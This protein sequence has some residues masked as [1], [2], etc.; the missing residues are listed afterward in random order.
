MPHEENANAVSDI[1]G[2]HLSKTSTK[3]RTSL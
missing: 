2:G 3:E 1:S